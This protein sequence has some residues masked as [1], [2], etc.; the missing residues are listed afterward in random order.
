MVQGTVAGLMLLHSFKH[1]KIEESI[2]VAPELQGRGIGTRLKR[3]SFQETLQERDIHTIISWHSAYNQGTFWTN[4]RC[5]GT[6]AD[7]VPDQTFLPNIR[8]MTDDFKWEITEIP[9]KK[10]E[11]WK[12]TEGVRKH[13]IIQG[14][15]K[16]K[17]I[18]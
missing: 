13:D 17:F 10:S 7:F 3:T 4:A 9:S 8:C 18:F 2:R 12:I 11:I 14:L 15:Q 5:G 16:H 6:I 1:G